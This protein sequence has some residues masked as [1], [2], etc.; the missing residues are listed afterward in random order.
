MLE[1][2]QPIPMRLP[3][4]PDDALLGL[5]RAAIRLAGVA[6]AWHRKQRLL[7]D[8]AVWR[9][10]TDR[11]LA[12]LGIGRGEL[13]RDAGSGS[14]CRPAQRH[15]DAK[16]GSVLPAVQADVGAVPVGHGPNDRQPQAAAG[17]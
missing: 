6:R 16:P 8:L 4:H 5:A 13:S 15:R 7:R 10:M 9:G 12:D 1:P 14:E 17:L 3:I 2:S 11:D